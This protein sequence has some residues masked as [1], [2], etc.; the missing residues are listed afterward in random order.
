MVGPLL[1]REAKPFWDFEDYSN[2]CSVKASEMICSGVVLQCLSGVRT[3]NVWVT[4]QAYK[5][6]NSKLNSG[7]LLP[8]NC[9]RAAHGFLQSVLITS[10]L[11]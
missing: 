8:V 11:N 4:N 9:V 5:S 1:N 3:H 10:Y 7:P 6:L 2:F